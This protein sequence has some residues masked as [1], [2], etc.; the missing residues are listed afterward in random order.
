M[1]GSQDVEASP[2]GVPKKVDLYAARPGCC[3]PTCGDGSQG[4]PDSQ[5]DLVALK[6][7]L[8]GLRAAP[9]DGRGCIRD[10]CDGLGLDLISEE[11]RMLFSSRL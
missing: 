4:R 6:Q 9:V 3:R 2:D 5:C 8:A 11:V 7:R 10:G 1:E